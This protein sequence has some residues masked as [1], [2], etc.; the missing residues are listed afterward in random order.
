MDRRR[1]AVVLVWLGL[2]A[3]VI[4]FSSAQERPER[5]YWSPATYP[6][7]QR[8]QDLF[9]CKLREAAFVCDPNKILN[10]YEANVSDSGI[11]AIQD[12]LRL[13]RQQTLCACGQNMTVEGAGCNLGDE[14]GYTIAVALAEYMDLPYQRACVKNTEKTQRT[15]KTS[16]FIQNLTD[17]RGTINTRLRFK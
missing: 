8:E 13:V 10:P 1:S 16:P 9:Y 7:P 6:N 11:V 5:R 17:Q 4:G 3:I 12:A 14:R 2:A 15:H